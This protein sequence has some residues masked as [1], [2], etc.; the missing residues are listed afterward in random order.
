MILGER[1]TKAG[2][3][4]M[5]APKRCKLR[6]REGLAKPTRNELTQQIFATKHLEKIRPFGELQLA[7]P[8]LEDLID[9]GHIA[10]RQVALCLASQ[11]ILSYFRLWIGTS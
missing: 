3:M 6:L 2:F 11:L 5:S 7:V 10:L 1:L 4:S 8:L 9:E